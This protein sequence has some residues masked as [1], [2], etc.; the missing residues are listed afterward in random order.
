MDSEPIRPR[1]AALIAKALKARRQV[2]L[3][4]W[5]GTLVLLGLAASLALGAAKVSGPGIFGLNTAM[6]VTGAAICVLAGGLVIALFAARSALTAV[7]GYA[8]ALALEASHHADTLAVSQTRRTDGQQATL[9]TVARTAV[10]NSETLLIVQAAEATDRNLLFGLQGREER[11][12]RQVAE[13]RRDGTALAVRVAEDERTTEERLEDLRAAVTAARAAE[14]RGLERAEAA[15]RE[16]K[17]HLDRLERNTHKAVVEMESERD[18]MR[19]AVSRVMAEERERKAEF[20]ALA[21]E[22]IRLMGRVRKTENLA[23]GEPERMGEYYRISRPKATHHGPFGEIYAIAEVEGITAARAER[24]REFGLTNSEHLWRA[25][26]NFL[27]ALLHCDAKDVQRWQEEAELMA[28]NG[29]GRERARILVEA[30]VT[31]IQKLGEQEPDGVLRMVS[32]HG[33]ADA[34]AK[35]GVTAANVSKWIESAHRMK[36]TT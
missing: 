1:E 5:L 36:P 14:R 21:A 23:K 15:E 25:N 31:S 24:L 34:D 3:Y 7:D 32:R 19:S 27:A 30:G 10:R 18:R 13:G 20:E 35:S 22:E 33:G 29:I 16:L 8:E 17:G 11:L 28:V 2:N 6:A 12:E 26:P 4:A 9:D